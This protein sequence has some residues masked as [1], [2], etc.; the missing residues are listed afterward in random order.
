M[1]HIWTPEETEILRA[2]YPHRQTSILAERMGLPR[3]SIEQKAQRL[4]IRKTRECL[5]RIGQECARKASEA[6]KRQRFQKGQKPWN[7]GLKGWTAG[8]NAESSRFK[9]GNLS[10]ICA[11][12]KQPIGAERIVKEG[13]RQRKI[14]DT[15]YPPRDWKGLHLIVWEEHHGPIPDGHIVVFKNR[16]KS[17]IRI[18]NMECITRRENMKRNSIHNLP[19]VLVDLIYRNNCL[20]ATITKRQKREKQHEDQCR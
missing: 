18:D 1:R 17:D 4:G 12:R 2:E 16:D 9:K 10:G 13:Y 15:G 7:A 3:T 11:L 20:K 19:S 6:G 5:F 14:S 8:G